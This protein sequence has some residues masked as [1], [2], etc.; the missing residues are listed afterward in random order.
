MLSFIYLT[1]IIAFL[2]TFD[3]LGSRYDVDCCIYVLILHGNSSAVPGT[4]HYTNSKIH[5]ALLGLFWQ[6]LVQDEL[7]QVYG[8]SDRACTM[9]DMSSLKYMEC[10][11]KESLRLYATAPNVVRQTSENIE[12]DGYKV[13]AGTKVC[14]QIFSLQ[15]NPEYFPD[16]LTYDPDRFLPDRCVGRHPFAFVPFSA[17]PRNCLGQWNEEI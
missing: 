6:K 13:P 5:Y 3:H 8:D 17:G 12:L 11:F 14:L 9:N 16:P 7:D 4:I 15:R 2:G 10:C 1:S